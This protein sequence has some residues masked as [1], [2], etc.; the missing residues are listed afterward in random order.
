MGELRTM[1]SIERRVAL[2]ALFAVS[3][4]GLIFEI[5]LT[6]LFSLYFQ[7]HFTFL[8][9]SLAILGLSVGAASAHYLNTTRLHA[10]STLTLVLIALSGALTVATLII[11]LLPS[12]NSIFPRALV[13]LAIFFLIGLFDALIFEN[14]ASQSG[15]FYAADLIGAALGVVAVLALLYLL[16]AFSIVIILAIIIGVLAVVFAYKTNDRRSKPFLFAVATPI[17]GI[18]LLVANLITGIVDFNPA[19]L[20]GASRDKT[21]ISILQD[22]SQ[23]A[24]I[25][26]TGW[27]SLR[28]S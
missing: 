16:S 11:A 21:M 20:S 1:L 9:V 7:Y 19:R 4:A 25:I 10:A 2:V 15:S 24:K 23:S 28:T 6:R 8:A 27:S 26:Y 3:A 14:F 5:V 17:A 13:A 22:A 18:I 12:A